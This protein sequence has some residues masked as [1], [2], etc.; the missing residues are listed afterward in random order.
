MSS[1]GTSPERSSQSP[2]TSVGSDSATIFRSLSGGSSGYMGSMSS[3]GGSTG[4]TPP[5]TVTCSRE[6]SLTSTSLSKSSLLE[7]KTSTRDSSCGEVLTE[8]SI[9]NTNNNNGSSS[10]GRCKSSSDGN[11]S[12]SKG[13]GAGA[14]VIAT[15]DPDANLDADESGVNESTTS[16]NNTPPFGVA[17]INPALCE[18]KCSNDSLST[19][20][21]SGSVMEVDGSL[22][23][24]AE[25]KLPINDGLSNEV[26]LSE[27]SPDHS[28]LPGNNN[29][30][31]IIDTTHNIVQSNTEHSDDINNDDV[32]DTDNEIV[33]TQSFVLQLSP[34]QATQQSRQSAVSSSQ[35][36]ESVNSNSENDII[37]LTGS[38]SNSLLNEQSQDI[39]SSQTARTP[40]PS[41]QETIDLTSPIPTQNSGHDIVNNRFKQSTTSL[42]ALEP[43]TTIQNGND[44]SNNTSVIR[45]PISDEGVTIDQ[46]SSN[47]SSV[48]T[49]SNNTGTIPIPIDGALMEQSSSTK[50]SNSIP[51]QSIA[52]PAANVEPSIIPINK[53]SDNNVI[54]A[55][56]QSSANV[57]SASPTEHLP[58]PMVLSETN[59][60]EPDTNAHIPIPIPSANESIANQTE[61]ESNAHSPIPIPLTNES[62]TNQTEPD[63]NVHRPKPIP[64]ANEC[65]SN[66]TESDSNVHRP[67]PIQSANE[68][69]VGTPNQQVSHQSFLEPSFDDNPDRLKGSKPVYESIQ[70]SGI[71]ET[72]PLLDNTVSIIY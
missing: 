8:G 3:G 60:T 28:L 45:Q 35:I 65:N 42:S 44:Q 64:S 51:S 24:E 36:T 19:G 33:S 53:S 4:F 48:T 40:P 21:K 20:K 23:I 22:P 13:G 29:N 72:P 66:Q 70:C 37:D 12:E 10:D 11:E 57:Q 39:I 41:L 15:N 55:L 47:N 52:N 5:G 25:N 30:S 9:D 43:L 61:P 49:C 34:S 54:P 46:S 14:V 18:D 26:L 31:T 6:H 62:I 59:Q 69:L 50:C 58:E 17:N 56:L 63:T 38:L 71:D 27:P 68:P 32:M 16:N 67:K 7:S 2:L 1:T